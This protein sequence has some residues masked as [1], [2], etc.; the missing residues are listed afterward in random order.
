MA[1]RRKKKGD[2]KS[3]VRRDVPLSSR[4]ANARRS[5]FDDWRAYRAGGPPTA[6]TPFRYSPSKPPRSIQYLKAGN[7]EFN[8]I[9]SGGITD[10]ARVGELVK[11]G[12]IK[13]IRRAFLCGKRQI[14]KE[15]LFANR[16]AGRNQRNSPGRGGTYKR[17]EESKTSCT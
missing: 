16:I 10:G 3:T 9:L 7:P 12:S 8:I 2:W 1:R 6:R 5:T 14:R 17:T 13:D 15:V 4:R 11:A